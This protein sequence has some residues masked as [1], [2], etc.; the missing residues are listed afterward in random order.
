[1]MEF[2]RS[3]LE[4]EFGARGKAYLLLSYSYGIIGMNSDFGIALAV[5]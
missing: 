5:G 4:R 1:M 3:E 2:H